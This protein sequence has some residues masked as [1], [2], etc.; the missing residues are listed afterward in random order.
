MNIRLNRA[1]GKL[2]DLRINSVSALIGV[3][4][5]PPSDAPKTN[6][7]IFYDFGLG[8]NV[9]FVTQSSVEVFQRMGLAPDWMPLHDEGD[10]HYLRQH[11]IVRMLEVEPD[12][13]QGCH[14]QIH[15]K[16]G[17]NDTPKYVF[18]TETIAEID[19]LRDPQPQ[20]QP[21]RS[22]KRGK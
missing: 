19:Q 20:P 1:D 2:V 7:I 8:T 17:P 22:N 3:S 18:V 11:S 4:R 9:E 5:N 16:T 6:T 12:Q 21:P 13:S 14:T 15:F 10:T